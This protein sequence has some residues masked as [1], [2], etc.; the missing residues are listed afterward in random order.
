MKKSEESRPLLSRRTAEPPKND[1]KIEN[2]EDD[3]NAT[4][5][6]IAFGLMLLF[7]LANRIFG[8]LQTYPMHNYPLFNNILSVFIYVPICF[9]Y[10]IPQLWCG[11]SITKEQQEIPKYKFA[12]MG[13]YDSFAGIMQTFAINYISNASMIVLVQQSAIPISML[14]SKYALNSTYTHM[15]YVGSSIVLLGIVVV[16]IPNFLQPA[17]TAETTSS[18]NESDPMVQLMWLGVLVVSCV[19][20]CLSSVYKE[21]ALGEV[22]IDITYLNGWVA[23]FQFLIAL[24]LCVPLSE[25]QHIPMNEIAPHMYNGFKCWMGVNSITVESNPSNSPLDDCSSAPLYVNLYLFFNVVYNFLIVIILKL[26]S[27]NILYMSS[28]VIVPL[29]NVVFS[30][31]FI[32]GNQPLRT[33]DIIGLLVIMLGLVIYRFSKDLLSLFQALRGTKPGYDDDE[34]E[35]K[36]FSKKLLKDAERKQ[37]RYLGLNQME[38]L[39]SLLDLRLMKE[40]HLLLF[41][42]PQQIRGHFYNKINVPPSPLLSNNRAGYNSHSFSPS[43]PRGVSVKSGSGLKPAAASYLTKNYPFQTQ[44]NGVTISCGASGKI[45]Q[46]V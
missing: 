6:A 5:L 4:G 1:G 25:V 38:S 30:L 26:G 44:E 8:R 31:K 39:Q 32:P 45:K 42:S 41:R 7:S 21:K 13:G 2:E 27:A 20:M 15:Q 12:V 19:P 33:W 9:A 23:I 35:S 11:K 16:L 17:S 37:L 28:T 3:K 36:H 14:I 18:M 24:P 22:D 40:K 34:L 10:I 29:S 43:L 46:T